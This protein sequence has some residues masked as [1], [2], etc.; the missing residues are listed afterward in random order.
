MRMRSTLL[1]S[2]ARGATPTALRSPSDMS[3][4]R[5]TPALVPGAE[6]Y[7]GGQQVAGAPHLRV[8][9]R[10][11]SQPRSPGPK[12]GPGAVHLVAERRALL[13]A[14]TDIHRGRLAALAGARALQY[15]SPS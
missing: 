13:R 1:R 7:G 9:C 11:G 4:G 2:S 3:R 15:L 12:T 5:P 10:G 6:P 8:N 14:A